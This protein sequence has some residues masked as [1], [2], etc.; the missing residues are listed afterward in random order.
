MSVGVSELLSLTYASFLISHL[1]TQDEGL[2]NQARARLLAIEA[3]QK[4]PGVG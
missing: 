3:F 2:D 4:I 1:S